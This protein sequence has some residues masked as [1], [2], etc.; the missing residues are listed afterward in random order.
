MG[1]GRQ[2]TAGRIVR[3]GA[4]NRITEVDRD[5]L[6]GTMGIGCIIDVRCGWEREEK[7]DVPTPGVE[8]LHIPFYDLEK[9]GIEYTEP[10]VGTKTV[11]RDDPNDPAPLA[12]AE[13]S[14]LFL[15][16]IKLP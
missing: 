8:N 7:P 13:I 14:Q 5:L 9:V 4:L 6:F 12:M 15:F 10:A 16:E 3:G 1:E 2:V 11:G